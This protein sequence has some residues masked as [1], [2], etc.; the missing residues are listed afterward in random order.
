MIFKK[1]QIL[2]IGAI[3][4]L[5]IVYFV[6]FILS[7][8]KIGVIGMMFAI[9]PIIVAASIYGRLW[10]GGVATATFFIS[11]VFIYKMT[12]NVEIKD[13]AIALVSMFLISVGIFVGWT[14]DKEKQVQ[15]ELKGRKIIEDKLTQTELWYRNI[16]N[17]VNDAVLVE[18]IKGEVLDVN[19]RA[20]EIFGWTREEFLTKTT[21]DMVP[22]EFEALLP[23][24]REKIIL[25]DESFET[26]NIR[27]NGEYFPVFV[28]GRVQIVGEEKRLVVV[29]RDITEQKINQ[30]EIKRHHQFL[31]HIIESLTQ[32]FYVVNVDD[33][34]IAIANSAARGSSAL[35]RATT[36]YALT[37][38]I[39]TPCSGDEHPC[40]IKE[41][42][43]NRSVVRTEHI[44]YDEEGE[45]TY[46]E[47]YG[48]PIFNSRGNVS[49]MIE[50]FVDITERKK[51]MATLQ[52]AKDVAETAAK[53]KA[54]FLANMSHEIR[55]P[56]NAIYG[57][58]N[59]MLDTP[60]NAEQEDF[61]KTIQGGS[62]T[63]LKVIN[64]ILDFSKIEAGKME[65]EKHPFSLR[66]CVEDS[67]SLLS[68][69]ATLKNLKV[70]CTIEDG[71]PPVILG[72]ITRL[73]QI[74]VNLVNNA[75]KFTDKG[76]IM[77]GI[78][79]RLAENNLHELRFSVR[80]TGIGIPKDKMGRLFE[81]F[82]QVDSST[83]RKYGGSGLG[84]VI[85]RELAEK[86]GGKMW[87][88][89]EDGQGST[90]FFTILVESAKELKSQRSSEID[91]ELGKK[92]PLRILLV[93]DNLINQ[94]VASKLLER[95]S[96]KA[97]IA[98]TGIMALEALE[99]QTYDVVFMDIQMPEMDGN[100]AT[101]QIREKFPQE[102][103][104]Y[105]IAMTAHALK[106][107]REKYIARGMSDYIS[108]PIRVENLIKVL[109]KAK[110]L[111]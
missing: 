59:L 99:N 43:E 102:R 79:S 77:I 98:E 20:C 17:G 18:T 75:I 29:V 6:I 32:P 9:F 93:E 84:L 111:S 68:E 97:D 48:Y 69:K 55:T 44:H 41:V 3:F 60:L 86:M 64:D 89:S 23:D 36:C 2:E 25:F 87:V 30:N 1:K 7:F 63:L 42:V 101:K 66:V 47:V 46:F 53:T 104:P 61:I 35:E 83:T 4:V 24:E 65:L 14:A 73:R 39:D 45:K 38:Q 49:Q 62:D 109:E 11:L 70:T 103:Q 13:P 76:E 10:G 108:K 78:R 54:D 22:P 57:M 95:L 90:F 28:S 106:G 50:Y 96:Y 31:S 85:S 8:D 80:D 100:E 27:A 67:I 82:S 58:T 56:L 16:F 74:L 5:L 34:S 21:K 12:G 72:D 26:V 105:I 40:P 15:I 19:T 33:Y 51:A 71:T 52:K 110:P 94:K 81:S 91:F 92:H 107:D 37:H 88:E